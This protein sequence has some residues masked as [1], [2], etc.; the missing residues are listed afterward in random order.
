MWLLIIY[1]YIFFFFS[2]HPRILSRRLTQFLPSNSYTDISVQ[3]GGV[4]GMPGCIEHNSVI[5]KN[6]EDA[7][8]NQGNL[9][10]LR[11]D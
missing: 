9:A 2:P 10:I 5:S 6:I 4:P 1:I 8:R 11:L 3:K 7:K